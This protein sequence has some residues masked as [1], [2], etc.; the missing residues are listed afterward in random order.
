MAPPPGT[1]PNAGWNCPK[2]ADSRAGKSHVAY[3]PNLTACTAHATLDLRDRDQ[4]ACAQMSKQESERRFAC[5]LR[6]FR[7]VL[8]DAVYV[9]VRNEKVGVGALEH[10]DVDGAIGLGWHSTPKGSCSLVHSCRR[11]C[12]N[13]TLGTSLAAARFWLR[14]V[15]PAFLRWAMFGPARRR[16]WP[17]RSGKE[18]WRSALPQSS[19]LGLL[20]LADIC[21][22]PGKVMDL[23]VNKRMRIRK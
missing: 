10:E 2:I 23:V 17:Q 19:W 14:P 21:I 18:A 6:R 9:H 5:Q 11:G 3:Q 22:S 15:D 13:E 20:S 4:A 7:P 16:W 12:A 1:E 8:F